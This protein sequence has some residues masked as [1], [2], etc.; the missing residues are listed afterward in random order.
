LLAAFAAPV[1]ADEEPETLIR[2]GVEMRR[3]GDNVRA[4]GYFKRA[5]DIAHTARS[6]AQLGLVEQAL[7][8][9][10]DAEQHLTEALSNSDAW[11]EQNRQILEESRRVVRTHLGTVDV[12][13]APAGTKVE[14]AGRAAAPL[15]DDHL[16]WLA[17]GSTDLTFSASGYE[18]T[19]EHVTVTVGKSARLRLTLVA[20][21][22]PPPPKARPTEGGSD[23]VVVTADGGGG[24]EAPGRP[25]G[26]R[27][28][29]ITGLVTAGTGVALAATG[30]VLYSQ[31][32]SKLAAINRDAS[33]GT[34][35]NEANGNYQTLGNAGIALMIGGGVAVA[36][37]A[38]LYLVNRGSG[39]PAAGVS[40]G[41][42]PGAGGSVRVGGRF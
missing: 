2:Q 6:A 41:Y 3:R 20:K 36:A 32:S 13:G 1:F 42:V 30:V 14:P 9:F 4:H 12:R 18:P 33:A 16:V 24:A 11:V 17:P 21:A 25:A 38:I 27:A 31:G 39:E 28:L 26:S 5:Y 15:P 40:V 22:L 8:Y 19:T 34:P 37:G 23:R 29:R 35:Y 7:Q 10:A